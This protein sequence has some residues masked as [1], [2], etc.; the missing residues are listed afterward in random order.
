MGYKEHYSNSSDNDIQKEVDEI[1][2]IVYDYE[3]IN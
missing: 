3:I 2:N 1:A